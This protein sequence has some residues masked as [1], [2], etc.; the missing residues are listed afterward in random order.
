MASLQMPV[1]CRIWHNK[2]LIYLLHFLY[3]ICGDVHFSWEHF[4]RECTQTNE[5][6]LRRGAIY[7]SVYRSGH[8]S[9]GKPFIIPCL[10]GLAQTSLRISQQSHQSGPYGDTRIY[11]VLLFHVIGPNAL[12]Y[13][14]TI[15]LYLEA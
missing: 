8:A 6:G 2:W 5:T 1:L 7:Y 15:L 10:Y 4:I 12:Q 3:I 9:V 13:C 11:Q 14:T